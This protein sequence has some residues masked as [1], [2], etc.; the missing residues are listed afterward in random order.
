MDRAHPS[1]PQRSGLRDAAGVVIGAATITPFVV[2][3]IV[4]L[5]PHLLHLS[6]TLWMGWAAIGVLAGVIGGAVMAITG[7]KWWLLAIG[8]G[9]ADTMLVFVLAL[10]AAIT[11]H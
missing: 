11:G 5:A 2:L 9:L 4:R 7:S 6:P 1:V 8:A 3:V 10:A